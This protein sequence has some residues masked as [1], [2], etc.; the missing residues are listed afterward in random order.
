MLASRDDPNVE[1]HAVGGTLRRLTGSFVGPLTVRNI[2]ERFADRCF[3]SVTGVT[4]DGVLTDADDLE[5]AVKHA[6]IEQA[7]ESVL[8]LDDSKVSTRGRQA[9]APIDTT[10]LVLAHGISDEVAE[11]LRSQGASVQVIGAAWIWAGRKV[12]PPRSRYGV[13]VDSVNVSVLAVGARAQGV[14][15][16][17]VLPERQRHGVVAGRAAVG[18]QRCRARGA[19][20]IREAPPVPAALAAIACSAEGSEKAPLT[21]R[22]VA[23]ALGSATVSSASPALVVTVAVVAAV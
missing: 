22:P 4:G 14:V 20:D 3:L 2:R 13:V 19:A 7:D 12:S 15:G 5:A 23:V 8:M 6:M 16:R 18:E 1:V 21:R 10:A 11:R 9:I 17:D